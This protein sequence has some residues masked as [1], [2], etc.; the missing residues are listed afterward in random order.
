MSLIIYGYGLSYDRCQECGDQ[1]N[2]AIY[3]EEGK[4]KPPK[5]YLC[6]NCAR[7]IQ[8]N[9]LARKERKPDGTPTL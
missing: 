6:E 5:L 7:E 3:I 8:T 1:W 2:I 9:S 4:R